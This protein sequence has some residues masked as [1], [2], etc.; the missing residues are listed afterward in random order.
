MTGVYAATFVTANASRLFC[1]DLLTTAC[2]T[3][4]NMTAISL[5]DRA[6]T[7][8][9]NTTTPRFPR[10]SIALCAARDACTVFCS[11][12]LGRSSEMGIALPALAQILT[13]PLHILATDMCLRP[14]TVRRERMELIA[15]RFRIVCTGR[16]ARIV[17]A[18]GIGC[19]INE[20]MLVYLSSVGTRE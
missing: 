1:S 7:R 6:F 16:V 10:T 17:P 13:T 3:L 12:V 15:A 2:T 4:V 19:W 18:F 14:A 11:F 5:K 20:S 9:F 8:H